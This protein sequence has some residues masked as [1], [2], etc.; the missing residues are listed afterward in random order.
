MGNVHAGVEAA[1]GIAGCVV[2]AG[3]YAAFGLSVTYGSP[4]RWYSMVSNVVCVVNSIAFATWVIFCSVKFAAQDA[5]MWVPVYAENVPGET[6]EFE[7]CAVSNCACPSGAPPD[8][9]IISGNCTAQL[10]DTG[11]VGPCVDLNHCCEFDVTSCDCGGAAPGSTASC[12][13]SRCSQ[14]RQCETRCAACARSV[15]GLQFALGGTGESVSVSFTLEC[16]SQTSS[17]ADCMDRLERTWPTG[18]YWNIYGTSTVVSTA[19][20]LNEDSLLITLGSG[21]AVLTVVQWCLCIVILCED[22]LIKREFRTR[23][24]AADAAVPTPP[25]RRTD[26]VG[27]IGIELTDATPAVVIPA[28][29]MPA[30]VIPAGVEAELPPQPDP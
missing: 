20:L 12:V 18:M 14:Y 8:Q 7:C 22:A 13:C 27:G 1:I 17:N 28:N 16:T 5:D 26:V 15:T 30:V 19:S 24:N 23:G 29:M 2:M 25:D 3:A 4:Y 11:T 6:T 21:I 9:V 10:A